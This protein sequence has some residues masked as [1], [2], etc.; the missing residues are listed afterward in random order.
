MFIVYDHSHPHLIRHTTSA[1]DL[2]SKVTLIGRSEF[3]RS[4]NQLPDLFSGLSG[5]FHS[6]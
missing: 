5:T 1:V 4:A 6:Q 3:C 2:A